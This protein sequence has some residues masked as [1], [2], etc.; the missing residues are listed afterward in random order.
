ME[1]GNLYTPEVSPE[2]WWL[3]DDPASYWVS[4][5]FQG[6]TVKLRGGDIYIYM[7]YACKTTCFKHIISYS[8]KSV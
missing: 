6:R 3:E 1:A 8:L 5:T 7:I 2:K 4:V